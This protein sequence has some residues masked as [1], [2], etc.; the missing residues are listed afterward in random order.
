[1]SLEQAFTAKHLSAEA[2]AALVA[3]RLTTG[4]GLFLAQEPLTSDE[5]AQVLVAIVCHPMSKIVILA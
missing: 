2:V 4:T 1:M 3:C 5:H